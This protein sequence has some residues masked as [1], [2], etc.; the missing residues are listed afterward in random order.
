MSVH[1]THSLGA[2]LTSLMRICNTNDIKLSKETGV[3]FTTIARMRSVE[4]ANPTASSLRPI[5]AY[6]GISVS[7]LLGDEPLSLDKLT[8]QVAKPVQVPLICW[9]N[10]IVFLQNK[11]LEP[12]SIQSWVSTDFPVSSTSFCLK[13][14]D[15]ALTQSFGKEAVIVVD[16]KATPV[17][18]DYVLVRSE[19]DDTVFLKRVM[20]D[21]DCVYLISVNPELK[22]ATLLKNMHSLVGI[23]IEIRQHCHVASFELPKPMINPLFHQS[24]VRNNEQS[25][26]VNAA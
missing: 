23:V 5:A 10:V 3:P 17:S 25:V 21:G 2:V 15:A 16:P 9:N 6:F 20:F 24:V 18:M 8:D 14:R 19:Y 1:A 22:E 7:Q 26:N 13:L 11:L 4:K 12:E